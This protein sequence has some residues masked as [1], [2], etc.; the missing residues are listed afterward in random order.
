MGLVRIGLA[1]IMGSIGPA[2]VGILLYTG[3]GDGVQRHKRQSLTSRR[4]EVEFIQ[5]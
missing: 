4:E 3:L 2:T 5:A 1:G